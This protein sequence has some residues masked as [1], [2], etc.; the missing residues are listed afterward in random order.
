MKT[1]LILIRH[2]I[3]KWNKQ[4]RYC[5]CRNIG[6]SGEGRKQ[7]KQLHGRLK[8]IKF[9]SIYVSDRKRAIQTA[10]IVFKGVEIKKIKQL[11]EIN[12]GVLEGLSYKEIVKKYNGIY[13]K[14]LKNPYKYNIPKAE[15]MNGFQKRVR[16]AIEKIIQAN[17]GKTIAMVCHG[18]TIGV[19]I[20]SI[21]KSEGFW[22]Y[23]PSA[24][25]ITV[26]DYK[27]GEPKIKLFNSKTASKGSF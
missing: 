15:P 5:G 27:E 9:D 8:N 1:R 6:I 17:R 4:R 3:T 19:F 21:L 18:G 10:K 23:V 24:A 26:I 14:W 20:S 25:S 2:A 11:R 7:A 12:F 16:L 13:K 22:R